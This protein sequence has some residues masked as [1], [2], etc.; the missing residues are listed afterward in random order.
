MSK[1]PSLHQHVETVYRR[2]FDLYQSADASSVLSPDLLP[3]ALKEIGVVCEQLQVALKELNSQTQKIAD[4]QTE[5]QAE[6]HRYQHLFKLSPDGYLIIDQDGIIQEVNRAAATLLNLP[7]SFLHG[8]SLFCL[9]AAEDRSLLKDKLAELSSNPCTEVSLSL[10]RYPTDLFDAALTIAELTESRD[11][12]ILGC[13][14]R[15]ITTQ[16]RATVALDDYIHDPCQNRSLYHYSRGEIIAL[17]PRTLW[18]VAQGIVKL[19]TLSER[20]EEILVGMAGQS[21]V[22]GSNLTALPTYQATALSKVKLAAIPLSEVVQS[23]QLAQTV[24]VAISQRLRQT[25]GFLAIHGQIRV[26]DRF[27]QL[28]LMLQQAFGE[29]GETGTRLSIR[30]TH[31][32]FASACCTTRVTITRLLSKWQQEGK[33]EIDSHNHLIL[34]DLMAND[35]N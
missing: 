4:A 35:T 11:R 1:I 32:D 14:I 21:M 23:P 3:I 15:D 7:Q 34:K 10:Y 30:L 12:T 6:R 5:I 33:L 28:L 20:G 17:E 25:E 26:E 8:K 9:V 27:K 13:V 24:M 16:K 29:V 18:F 22:F 2:L 31:Q 19:T